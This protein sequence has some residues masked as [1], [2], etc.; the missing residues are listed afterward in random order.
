MGSKFAQL[1]QVLC[2][3]TTKGVKLTLNSEWRE[4]E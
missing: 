1:I 4:M 3:P 2:V